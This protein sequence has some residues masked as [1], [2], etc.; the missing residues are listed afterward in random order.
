MSMNRLLGAVRAQATMAGQGRFTSRVGQVSSY[1]PNSYSVKV[2][3]PPDETESGW[4]PIGAL[5][6]GNGFGIFAAPN[7]GDQVVI[8]FQDAAPD[9]P[10]AALRL[11]DNVRPAAVVPA[12]EM[13][14]VHAN[15][16]YAKLTNDGKLSL[17][18]GHGASVVLDGAGNIASAGNWTHTGNLTIQSGTT[19]VAAITSNGH[20][21]SSTHKHTG[22]TTGSGITGAPQ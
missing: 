14:I 8:L 3:F 4:I 19:A 12:G 21:I 1:D 10:I 9:A 20:D 2:T 15:G 18:D 22:V 16:Q 13:W 5:S 6:V 11:F 7:I 17:N